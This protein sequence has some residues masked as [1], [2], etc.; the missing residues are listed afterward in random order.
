MFDHTCIIHQFY[1]D[2]SV[3]FCCGWGSPNRLALSEALKSCSGSA[4]AEITY[5]IS[6]RDTGRFVRE[7][8]L[9]MLLENAV[10]YNTVSFSWPS[11]EWRNEQSLLCSSNSI[12]YSCLSDKWDSWRKLSLEFTVVGLFLK[13]F[14]ISGWF[15]RCSSINR[16]WLSVS[17][18]SIIISH[19]KVWYSSDLDALCPAISIR[20]TF[21]PCSRNL[22]A[23]T[24]GGQLCG[25]V[26]C[27]SDPS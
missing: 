8:H 2:S 22:C 10:S 21:T 3:L 12:S 7:L 14:S 9:S 13:T 23:N 26:E 17:H 15:F 24:N 4:H 18:A 11:N 19:A 1:S 25:D 20:N 16:G 27:Y 6:S 5:H